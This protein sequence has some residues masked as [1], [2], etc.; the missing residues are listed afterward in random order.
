MR[1][2]PITIDTKTYPSR[3]S[4]AKAMGVT[5]DTLSRWLREGRVIAPRVN[6]KALAL[7][8]GLNPSTVYTRI[9]NGLSVQ[10]ALALR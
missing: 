2:R 1:E 4:A 3:V 8:R 6:I 7:A 9:Y 10:R 5:V